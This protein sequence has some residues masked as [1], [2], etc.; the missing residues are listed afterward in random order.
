MRSLRRERCLNMLTRDQIQTK[1]TELDKEINQIIADNPL[2]KASGKPAGFPVVSWLVAIVVGA[3][4]TVGR[5]VVE[6]YVPTG[7]PLGRDQ[8]LGYGL[9][10]AVAFG[11]LAVG[12]TLR[13]LMSR[14]STKGSYHKANERLK[15]LRRQ[16]QILEDQLKAG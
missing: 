8:I 12:L 13:W 5:P 9:Y 11:V 10:V 4:T 6:G 2:R 3:A 16:R 14:G 15:E 7:L 1:L